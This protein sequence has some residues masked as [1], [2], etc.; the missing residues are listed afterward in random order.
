MRQL[1]EWIRLTLASLFM[2]G[3]IFA[4]AASGL[5]F[6]EHGANFLVVVLGGACLT[7]SALLVIIS[8]IIL[9]T[10]V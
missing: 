1:L 10:E 8:I 2:L 4:M 3:V 6:I 9:N 7:I 5:M